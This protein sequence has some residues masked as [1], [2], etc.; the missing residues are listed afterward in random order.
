MNVYD[1]PAAASLAALVILQLIMLGS[2]YAGTPPHPPA[3][4][5]F[6]AIAPFLGA[7]LSIA[8][9]AIIAG[10]TV[11]SWG[12]GLG[13]AAAVC[14]LISFGPQKYFDPQ[15]ALIWPAVICGQIAAL[16][17][18]ARIVQSVRHG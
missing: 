9:S 2:L 4:I 16:A 8:V 11:S 13:L 10:P 18:I 12:R 15:F 1:R 5:P 14:G 6:F 7:S 17:L 3:A